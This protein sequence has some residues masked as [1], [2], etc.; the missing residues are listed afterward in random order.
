MKKFLPV[1]VLLALVLVIGGCEKMAKEAATVE[2]PCCVG[3]FSP[4]I[5]AENQEAADMLKEMGQEW[6]SITLN[7]DASF[8]LKSEQAIEGTYVVADSTVTLT[9]TMIDG[10]EATDVEP[11]VVAISPCKKVLTMDG[12]KWVKKPSEKKIT[13]IVEEVVEKVDQVV[14]K[15]EEVVEKAAEVVE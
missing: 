5:T 13:E 9:Y 2:G 10:A 7:K 12:T 6:P 14:E 15:V 8:A 4:E 1:V 11:V 3:T